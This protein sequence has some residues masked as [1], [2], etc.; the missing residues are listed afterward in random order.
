MKHEVKW[1]V[2]AKW[3][4]YFYALRKTTKK[5]MLACMHRLHNEADTLPEE[6]KSTLETNE[7]V[8]NTA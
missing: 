5:K 2:I 6:L 3:C 4:E 8:Y 7:E 1:G